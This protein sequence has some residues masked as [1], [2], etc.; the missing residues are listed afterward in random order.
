[1]LSTDRNRDRIKSAVGVAVFHALIGYALIMGFGYEAVRTVAED[2]KLVEVVPEPL[3]PPPVEPAKPKAENKKPRAEKP[4]GAASPKNLKDTPSPI[5]APPP[6]IPLPLPPPI[7]AA[8]IA[9]QG[10]RADAGASDV[11]GPGTGNG[12]QGTGTGS[13]SAG[14][15]TGGG[16]GGSGIARR[17]RYVS[18]T[19]YSSDL[20]EGAARTK[21]GGTV[22]F[23][24]TVGASG[25]VTDCRVTRSSGR[26]DLDETTC[27]LIKKRLRYRPARDEEGRT[28]PQI[29]PGNHRWDVAE[30]E[31]SV[32]EDDEYFDG[33]DMD[34]RL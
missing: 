18:G 11:P 32:T 19:I 24:Y 26:L 6:V 22:L 8:P 28:V 1:M 4:E 20:P 34:H 3:P 16:G 21:V 33:P 2:L 25:R 12:G 17:A 10:N 15:G 5:V 27:R 9:G 14:E 29:L 30:R 7:I 23:R 31:E 13:G